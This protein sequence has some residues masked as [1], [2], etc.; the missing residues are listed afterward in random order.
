MNPLRLPLALFTFL[1]IGALMPVAL[2]FVD[3]YTIGLSAETTF[4]ASMAIPAMVL[5]FA[6]SWLQPGG[7]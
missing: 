4:I 5:L 1:A 3:E 7:S 6:A 2:Y